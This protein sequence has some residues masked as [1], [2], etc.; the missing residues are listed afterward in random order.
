[1]KKIDDEQLKKLRTLKD[2]LDT[3]QKKALSL[4]GLRLGEIEE[5]LGQF[6]IERT[7]ERAGTKYLIVHRLEKW[8]GQS[9]LVLS[10]RLYPE[11]G[12]LMFDQYEGNAGIHIEISGVHSQPT[13][14][15]VCHCCRPHR[16][17]MDHKETFDSAGRLNREK[18][19]ALHESFWIEIRATCKKH[20]VTKLMLGA[21]GETYPE[22]PITQDKDGLHLMPCH[23][24]QQ[25]VDRWRFAAAFCEIIIGDDAN[26]FD[27]LFNS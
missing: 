16:A 6:P 24:L 13:R 23:S 5:Q 7:L 20:G 19:K 22:I 17:G 26:P 1:M 27:S 3:L 12:L 2:E 8:T 14:Q 25:E 15:M 11:V 9:C 4:T 21:Y 10:S 18:S